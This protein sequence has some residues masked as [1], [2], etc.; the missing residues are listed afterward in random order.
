[1][2]KKVQGSWLIHHTNKLQNVTNQGDYQNTFVAGKAGILLSAI[3]ETNQSVITNEKL[4]VLANASN[5]NTAFELPKLLEVLKEQEL[6]DVSSSGVGVLG[7]TTSSALQHTTNIF[8]TL[9]PKNIEV[10]AI[11][12]AEIA[13]N[14]PVSSTEL[15]EKIS[16]EYQLAKNEV[17]QLFHDSENIGFVDAEPISKNEKLLFNGNLFRRNSAVKTKAVL[18]SLKVEEQAS[19][20]ELTQLLKQN[21]CVSY[22]D[23]LRILGEPLFK[24]VN[25]IGFFDINV[26]SNNQEEVGYLTLPSAFS[27]FSN[28]MVDDAFDLAKAFVASLTYGMTKSAYA[29]GQI[30]MIDR[31]LGALIDGREVGPVSAIGQDYK[32]L[33]LKG[34]VAIR[35]GTK[36][37]RSGPLMRLLKKEVGELALQAIRQ[38]DVS[39]QSIQSLPGA[40]IT[41]F[42]GPEANREIIRR[43]QIQKSPFETNDMI[44]SLRTGG[45]F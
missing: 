6:I 7:V 27:K 18:D 23:A 5:I 12:L 26:V 19:L 1:M 40:A 2:D 37:G 34:V 17:K 33:E 14:K 21:A 35:H 44:S 3:S 41:K 24:K 31:L 36:N 43:E 8:E 42:R 4:N 45:G 15:S 25:S 38:G 29:R 30:S 28:S 13:S 9:D 10:S 16:D 39:E 20:T 22:T 32:V 11:E